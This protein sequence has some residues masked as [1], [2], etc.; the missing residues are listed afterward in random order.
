MKKFM[1][2]LGLVCCL[3]LASCGKMTVGK[4]GGADG[5]VSDKVS[6]EREPVRMVN[7]DGSLYYETGEDIDCDASCGVMDG[8]LTK[9]VDKFE[10]PLKSGESN[11]KAKKGYWSGRTENTLE[12][13]VD[14]LDEAEIF[15]KIDTNQDVSKYKYCYKVEKRFS[16]ADDDSEFLVLANSMDITFDDAVYKMFGSDTEKMKDIYVISVVD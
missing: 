15:K 3:A 1:V 6:T 16:N 13:P 5:A 10:V 14:D 12:I 11:F 8:T 9:T 2:I 7:V 4:N